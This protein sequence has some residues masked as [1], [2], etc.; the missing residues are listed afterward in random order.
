MKIIYYLV[1]IFCTAIYTKSISCQQKCDFTNIKKL[2]VE[3]EGCLINCIK[4]YIQATS[5]KITKILT[6]NNI[7]KKEKELKKIFLKIIDIDM[8][9][10]NALGKT[11]R[12][13]DNN[14]KARYLESY[15]IYMI[16]SYLK[17]IIEY[18]SVEYKIKNIEIKVK[19]RRLRFRAILELKLPEY[20]HPVTVEYEIYFRGEDLKILRIKVENVSMIAAQR[21]DFEALLRK[22]GIENLLRFLV[23]KAN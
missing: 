1:F 7:E 12:S 15:Q 19:N 23:H 14:Q 20:D 3:Q 8:F 10:I 16:N 11:W 2:N 22:E 18:N 9:A 13:L 5:E 21:D 4:D 6:Y 17:K